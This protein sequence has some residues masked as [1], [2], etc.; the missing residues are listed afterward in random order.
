MFPSDLSVDAVVYMVVVGFAAARVF[1]FFGRDTLTAPARAW[2][3][4]HAPRVFHWVTCRWCAGFWWTVVV[5]WLASTWVWPA[6]LVAA[7]A[8]VAG[9]AAGGEEE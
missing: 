2:L 1:Q 5:F 8:Q 7:A 3:V 6:V 4:E 9:L